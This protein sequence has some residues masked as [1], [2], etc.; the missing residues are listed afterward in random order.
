MTPLKKAP[1][2]GFCC[3]C[4]ALKR[5]GVSYKTS[6]YARIKR[7]TRAKKIAE[8]SRIVLENVGVLEKILHW[9]AERRIRHHRMSSSIFPLMS[10]PKLRLNFSDLP[11][12][13]EISAMLGRA[14]RFAKRRGITLSFHPGQYDV[15]ASASPEVRKNS[16][17]DINLHADFMDLTGLPLSRKYPINIHVAARGDTPTFDADLADGLSLLNASARA[18]LAVENEDKGFWNV[19]RLLEKIAPLGIPITLDFLHRNCNPC[20]LGEKE[21]FYLCA[22]TWGRCTPVFHY[23]ESAS[24]E[25]RRAHSQFLALRPPRFSKKYI[26]EI[27]AKG[28]DDA[29]EALGS[30]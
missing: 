3:I 20:S 6:T 26:C 22:K 11:D 17:F 16:A 7:L 15:L 30:P 12:F 13:L 2:L 28:K 4:N 21:A 27:E 25:N 10:H 5:E 14:G 18:R 9:C 24:S 8:I 1:I 19:S 23:A 29:L